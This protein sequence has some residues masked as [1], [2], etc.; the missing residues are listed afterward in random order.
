MTIENEMLSLEEQLERW[1]PWLRDQKNQIDLDLDLTMS[2]IRRFRDATE[3]RNGVKAK[4]PLTIGT[5]AV[6]VPNPRAIIQSRYMT[7]QQVIADDLR[8]TWKKVWHRKAEKVGDERKDVCRFYRGIR[9]RTLSFLSKPNE[10][11]RPSAVVWDYLMKINGSQAKM[12]NDKGIDEKEWYKL[13]KFWDPTAQAIRLA[14]RQ[15]GSFMI[16]LCSI[17]STARELM[18]SD[19]RTRLMSNQFPLPTPLLNCWIAAHKSKIPVGK[20]G[21]LGDDY[22]ILNVQKEWEHHAISVEISSAFVVKYEHLYVDQISSFIP[23]I[24]QVPQMLMHEN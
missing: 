14:S 2:N 6:L 19:V 10:F 17:G 1:L 4:W 3:S 5:D 20:F 8:A 23:T 16:I 13:Y 15:Q 22:G 11:G 18:P 7:K 24:G 12:I 9:A 21:M